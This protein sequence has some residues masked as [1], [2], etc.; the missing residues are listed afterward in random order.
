[1]RRPSKPP[2]CEIYKTREEWLKARGIGG[3]DL[4]VILG[5]SKWGSLDEIFDRLTGKAEEKA[6]KPSERMKEGV[7]AEPLIRSLFALDT[8]G[9]YEVFA[10]PTRGNWLWRSASEPLVTCSPDGL[11]LDLKTREWGGLEIKDVELVKGEDREIW[12]RN[13]LPDQYYWQCIQYMVA[14]PSLEFV[15]LDAHLKYLAKL[16]D[17]WEF[18]HAEDRYFILRRKDL[19]TAKSICWARLREFEFIDGY[20]KK[21]IRPP[22]TIKL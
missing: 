21:G 12:E 7:K 11:L 13:S 1:M 10:P 18:D 3:S 17:G 4:A 6:D 20:V 16:G 22:L 8:R 5:V 19:A 15:V 14:I 2:L 9:K